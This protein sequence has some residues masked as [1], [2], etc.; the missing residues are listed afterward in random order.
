M[1]YSLDHFSSLVLISGL[2]GAG[3]SSV[4]DLLSDLGFFRIDNLPVQ[5]FGNF[6][7]LSRSS[8]ERYSHTALLLD[9][10]SDSKVRELFDTMR[11][12]SPGKCRLEVV[13]ADCET[14]KIINRYNETKRPHPGFDATRD[15][16][17]ADAITRERDMLQPIRELATFV[18][19]TTKLNIHE[20]KRELKKFADSISPTVGRKM[21]VNFV[22]FGFKNGLP[23]DIDLLIDVRFLTNPYFV[24]ALRDK[25]G[26]DEAVRK[27]V[28]E[29]PDAEQFI[30]KYG[31]LINFLLPRYA[32][33]GKSYLNIGVG[34][35]G[36]RHRSVAIADELSRQVTF[37]ECLVS[38]KH[39]DAAKFSS[40]IKE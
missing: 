40:Q 28:I 32:H 6:L 26:E 4:L 23:P 24:D 7:E 8:P 16:T 21:R 14:A 3:K 12:V 36:G 29:Q 13:F 30:A 37:S 5:L 20:L 1:S 19:D 2:S 25:T 38:V 35:T 10:D 18:I 17:L 39:R 11:R 31:E 27:F 33:E 9:V 15:K 22:S 34:C